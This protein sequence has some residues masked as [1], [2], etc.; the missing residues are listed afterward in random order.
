[1]S[2]Q[3][4]CTV[5][6]ANSDLSTAMGTP[7]TI[8]LEITTCDDKTWA[9]Y[10]WLTPHEAEILN[11]ALSSYRRTGHPQTRRTFA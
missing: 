9:H 3:R 2:T 7:D 10:I 11:E 8:R 1:M 5:R 4:T 6:V